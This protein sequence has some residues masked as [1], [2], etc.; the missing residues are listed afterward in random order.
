MADL[1]A[2]STLLGQLQTAFSSGDLATC[3][4]LLGRLKLEMTKMPALPPVYQQ[5]ANTQQQLE[6]ARQVLE[7]AVLLAV[8]QCDEAA[9][10]RNYAQLR[11]YFSDARG[12]LPPSGQE[13][14]L[15][16]LHLLRLLVANRIAEFHSELE[17]VPPEVQATPE[18]AQ[19][20]QLEQWLMEG[21][22]NKVLAARASAA[23]DYTRHFL[24]QLSSTVR[25]EVASCSERAYESLS[26]ADAASVLML[27]GEAEVEAYAREH[28]WEVSG[29]RIAFHKRGDSADGGA[30][31]TAPPAVDL[32]GHCLNYAREIERIV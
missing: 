21:A 18:V 26:V 19:V 25:E 29:G 8:R 32:I 28:G 1:A 14:A 4:Q 22:Y 16:G 3:K 13:G 15:T 6:L 23:S 27:G 7:L 5:S 9:F 31:G 20:V 10:E 2:A 30:D 17:V 12:M 24:D 11:V